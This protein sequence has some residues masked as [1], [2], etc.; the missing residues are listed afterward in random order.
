MNT[1]EQAI[2]AAVSAQARYAKSQNQKPKTRAETE[3]LVV[4][5]LNALN[6][7]LEES[8]GRAEQEEIQ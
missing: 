7:A 8:K 1:F 4:T 5:F 2:D 6:A 3:R